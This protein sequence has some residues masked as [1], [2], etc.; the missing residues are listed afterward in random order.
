M[1]SALALAPMKA[2][3]GVLCAIGP[4]KNVWIGFQ[5]TNVLQI[6]TKL[7][8]MSENRQYKA[9]FCNTYFSSRWLKGTHRLE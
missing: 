8:E 2:F 6:S 4:N 3:E 1:A 9:L 7:A 5:G